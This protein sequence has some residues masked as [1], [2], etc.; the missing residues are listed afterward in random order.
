MRRLIALSALAAVV[1][2]GCTARLETNSTVPKTRTYSQNIQTVTTDKRCQE[3]HRT[4][5]SQG[6]VK[7]LGTY[8]YDVTKKTTIRD[9]ARTNAA[10]FLTP[11][12]IQDVNDWWQAGAP[13]D[14]KPF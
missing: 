4:D 9:M 1:S 6:E 3:C 10:D 14:D 13:N 12:Q 2:L 7:G 11:Q 5:R 8:A